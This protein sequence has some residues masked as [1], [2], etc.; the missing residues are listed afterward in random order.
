MEAG[1][2]VVS[3]DR[4]RAWIEEPNTLM[5]NVEGDVTGDN[6]RQMRDMTDFIGAGNG[7]VIIMQD[8]SKAGAFTAAA[9]KEI[10]DDERTKRVKSV[11]C[12]GASFRMRVFMTMITKALKLVN[13]VIPMTLFAKDEAE[14]RNILAAERA[15]FEKES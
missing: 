5:I 2:D 12:I 11:I 6:M 7:P 14:A 8:L 1:N 13:P 10:L 3:I 9:R 4:H 15:R